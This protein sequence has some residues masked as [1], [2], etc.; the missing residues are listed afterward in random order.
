MLPALK[1]NAA[2]IRRLV[3][4][5]TVAA[6]AETPQTHSQVHCLPCRFPHPHVGQ[7]C[8][9]AARHHREVSRVRRPAAAVHPFV[10]ISEPM[11]YGPEYHWS[12]PPPPPLIP[13]PF[14]HLQ[15]LS[16]RASLTGAAAYPPHASLSS[17]PRGAGGAT[18]SSFRRL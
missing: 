3:A 5:R 9:G 6:Q 16:K 14:N 2:E 18:A 17:F 10:D 8:I 11:L 4:P 1:R 12:T 13:I 7:R 15:H